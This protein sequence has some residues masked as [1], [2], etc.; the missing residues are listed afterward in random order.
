MKNTFVVIQI[1]LS[2]LLILA[3]LFQGQGQ[4]LGSLGGGSDASF[5]TKRGLEKIL[6]R[7]TIVLAVA[8]L[9][10]LVAQFL[11]T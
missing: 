11:V 8:F 7:G 5:K 4:G 9:I 6:F 3:I 10:S 1:I 2:V